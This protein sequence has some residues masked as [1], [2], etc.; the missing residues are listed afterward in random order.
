MATVKFTLDAANPPNLTERE[1]QSLDTLT[2]GDIEAKAATDLDNPPITEAE[3]DRARSA[4]FVKHVRAR[5]GLS[6][7]E[8]ARRFRI[9]SARLRDLE[10]GRTACD[11]ALLAYLK[12]IDHVPVVVEK[13]LA[14]D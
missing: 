2:P 8:F 14:E 4:S 10:Q 9:N 11:S 3:F 12:V 6:Q 5:T 7:A 13:V 1:R